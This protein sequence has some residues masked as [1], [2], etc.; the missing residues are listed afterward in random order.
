MTRPAPDDAVQTML[1]RAADNSLALLY[2][3]DPDAAARLQRVWRRD[4]TSPSIVVAGAAGQGKSSLTNMLIGVPNLSPVGPAATPSPLEFRY[5]TTVGA[6]AH[7]PDREHPVPLSRG[8]VRDWWTMLQRLP[9]GMRPPRLI[10]VHHHAPL[11]RHLT[12]V[13]M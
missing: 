9:D 4:V 13:D 2:E 10:E 5:S 8:Y 11:L 6:R 12:L 3:I 7:L 1:V